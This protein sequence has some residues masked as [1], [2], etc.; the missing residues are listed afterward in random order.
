MG[1]NSATLKDKL[2]LVIS[3]YMFVMRQN[4][5]QTIRAI[6]SSLNLQ[7][8][9]IYRFLKQQNFPPNAETLEMI[10]DQMLEKLN[11]GVPISKE[12]VNEV[13]Q[14]MSFPFCVVIPR[15]SLRLSQ[16]ANGDINLMGFLEVQLNK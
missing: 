6:A 16:D 12:P 5:T 9:Q 14:T 3:K 11:A 7:P 10:L 4:K 2:T 15:R 13:R 1:I 8:R